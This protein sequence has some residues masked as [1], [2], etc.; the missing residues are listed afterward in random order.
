MYRRHVEHTKYTSDYICD[1]LGFVR[2]PVSVWSSR[3]V[4]PAT[5]YVGSVYVSN[6]YELSS[7]SPS[8]CS[9]QKN[10]KPQIEKTSDSGLDSDFPGLFIITEKARAKERK[11]DGVGVMKDKAWWCQAPQAHWAPKGP[12]WLRLRTNCENKIFGHIL[13]PGNAN[14]DSHRFLDADK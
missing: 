12:D 3:G 6:R 14:H 5:C 2:G 4:T 11:W 9:P 1:K 8:R 13:V 7:S 10:K